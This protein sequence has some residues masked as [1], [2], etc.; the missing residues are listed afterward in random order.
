MTCSLRISGL[1]CCLWVSCVAAADTKAR[2]ELKLSKDEQLILDLTNETRQQEGLA[3][4]KPNATLFELARAHSKN[5]ARQGQMNHVLDGKNPGDRAKQAGY[6][7]YV[8][9]NVASGMPLDPSAAF[10]LWLDSAGHKKNIL[11]KEYR[12][13]GIGVARNAS[14]EAYYTQVFGTPRNRR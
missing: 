1:F 12:E 7:G 2:P 5:M 11:R 4:L 3:S 13:I 6:R 9:E 8:G 14:G 10:Q